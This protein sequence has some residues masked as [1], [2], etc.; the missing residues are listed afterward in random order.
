MKFI[1]W[2]LSGVEQQEDNVFHLHRF[3]ARVE[4][5]EKERASPNAGQPPAETPPNEGESEGSKTALE[6]SHHRKYR[7]CRTAA[8]GTG[9]P[10]LLPTGPTPA[11]PCSWVISPSFV[12]GHPFPTERW[13]WLTSQLNAGDTVYKN[14]LY[15]NSR[16]TLGTANAHGTEAQ[17]AHTG[18]RPRAGEPNPQL[19]GRRKGPPHHPSAPVRHY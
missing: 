4:A 1:P 13:T 16:I 17:E 19:G 10:R 7:D 5:V 15:L 3:A 9:T 14:Y 18:S 8:S 12:T 11:S 2:A 6:T